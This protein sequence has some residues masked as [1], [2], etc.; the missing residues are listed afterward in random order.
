MVVRRMAHAL[1]YRY[2]VDVRRLP[3]RPD[4]VF[5]PRRKVVFVHGCFW[6]HHQDP[7]CRSASVP[8]TRTAFWTAKFRANSARDARVRSELV[9]A[10]WEVITIWECETRDREVLRDRLASILGPSG[11]ERRP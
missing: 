5:G 8:G 9:T 7:N 2:R 11:R 3:G 10:G 4:L 6:H 1:G